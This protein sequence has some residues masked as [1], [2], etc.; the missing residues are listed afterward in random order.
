[1]TNVIT[2]GDLAQF[3]YNCPIAGQNIISFSSVELVFK[4][5]NHNKQ[6]KEANCDY[7][8][9]NQKKVINYKCDKERNTDILRLKF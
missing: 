1:M 5:S 9:Q 4:R 2:I 6:L 8:L 3:A 7:K